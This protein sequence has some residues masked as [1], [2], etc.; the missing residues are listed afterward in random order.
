MSESENKIPFYRDRLTEPQRR[1]LEA[2]I[3]VQRLWPVLEPRLV[4]EIATWII[5][6]IPSQQ[7]LRIPTVVGQEAAEVEKM[8]RRGFMEAR[9]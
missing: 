1:R 6:G 4:V 7:H 2:L 3:A 8:L 5:R 9:S